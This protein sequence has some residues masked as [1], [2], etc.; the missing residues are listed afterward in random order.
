M[1]RQSIS[2]TT[3]NDD[4]LKQQVEKQEYFNKSEV[5]NALIRHARLKE[6]TEI[7]YIRSK[8]ISAENREFSTMTAED[9]K[10][11][12]LKKLGFHGNV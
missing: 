10:A 1:T 8:L 6:T 7:D 5:V 4:W 9:I 3:P 11:E 12:A 2:L